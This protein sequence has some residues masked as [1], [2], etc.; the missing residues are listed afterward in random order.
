MQ[1]QRD[2]DDQRRMVRRQ[3]EYALLCVVQP[4]EELGLHFVADKT[5]RSP[6]LKGFAP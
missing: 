5:Q 2:A 3:R 1:R 6:L 4:V